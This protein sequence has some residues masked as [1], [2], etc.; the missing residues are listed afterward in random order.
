MTSKHFKHFQAT[1]DIDAASRATPTW[2]W[3]ITCTGMTFDV[4]QL[5]CSQGA[6]S[7]V[8][9]RSSNKRRKSV[10]RAIWKKNTS[11]ST[12]KL[13]NIQNSTS[14]N[15][16][17]VCT[18]WTLPMSVKV[19]MTFKASSARQWMKAPGWADGPFCTSALTKNWQS[20]TTT[21]LSG[22]VEHSS[23][24]YCILERYSVLAINLWINSLRTQAV[25]AQGRAALH[26]LQSDGPSYERL[27]FAPAMRE[28]DPP[29]LKSVW[30]S[31]FCKTNSI[32]K[33]GFGCLIE[34]KSYKSLMKK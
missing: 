27:S 4:S 30:F 9:E 11:R 7:S 1:L 16:E 10:W 23:T 6:P 20:I 32:M 17:S 2:D 26:V 13:W 28:R 24:V 25:P 21:K 33:I 22:S 19:S 12:K 15:H 5:N 14:L 18:S 34:C 8:K 31:R 3:Q 29:S